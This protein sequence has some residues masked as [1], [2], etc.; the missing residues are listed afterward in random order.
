MAAITSGTGSTLKTT[1]AEGQ[2]L[3]AL[4]FLQ[5]QEASTV[6]NPLA[7]NSIDGAIDTNTMVFAGSFNMPAKQTLGTNGGLLISA[8]PYLSG[9]IFAAGSGGTFKSSTCEAYALETLMYLQF[10]EQN[11]LKNPQGRN[12]IS[13]SYNIDTAVY[14]GSFSLPIVLVIGPAGDVITTAQPYLLD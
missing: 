8:N 4:I 14:S 2:C 13:G 3:E 9:V 10:L 5:I 12:F 6:R 1:T 11:D 7:Q